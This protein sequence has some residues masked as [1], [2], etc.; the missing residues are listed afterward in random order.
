MLE[1]LKVRLS[2]LILAFSRV[3]DFVSPQVANHHLRVAIIASEIAQSFGVSRQESSD[4]FLAA[5]IHDIGVFSVRE[6]FEALEFE[7]ANPHLHAER[8][9]LLVKD[10]NRFSRAASLIRH[11]HTPWASGEGC[12]SNG[13]EVPIGAHV[14]HLADRIEVLIYKNMEILSQKKHIVSAIRCHSGKMFMP[15]LVEAFEDLAVRESFWFDA[16]SPEIP[17]IISDRGR[18]PDHE[19]DI[20]ELLNISRIFSN[21]IDYRSSFTAVHSTGVSAVS[22]MLAQ[23]VGF[24]DSEC[25][26]MTVAGYLH[27]I[28]KLAIP[29]EILDKP[30]KLTE[31]EFNIIKSHVYHSYRILEGVAGIETI[32]T[33]GSLHH[34]RIDG[35]GYP[36]HLKGS[37]LPI[38][39][40]IMAVADVFT[41]IT[42]DRPY[43]K[44]MAGEHAL[45]VIQ[46]M[47]Q[48][49]ALDHSI[50]GMASTYF[51]HLNDVRI[52][53]QRKAGEGYQSIKQLLS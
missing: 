7:M 28:G 33:W 40:R 34:E 53:A 35:T 19:L 42:E 8:G 5:T 20:T 51:G 48:N 18:L 24:S 21:I 22:S 16:I 13:E 31:E 9:Y 3:L 14:L 30:G 25:V 11:H 46:G 10:Y 37:R 32:N 45:K 41:A 1:N 2:D 17:Q 49:N 36:F 26:M 50:V 12:T 44:G 29:P 6:K 39:S 27:D 52:E 15:E 38:G 4:I 43:R 47:A 23:M